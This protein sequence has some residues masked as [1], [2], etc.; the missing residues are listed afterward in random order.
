MQQ[1]DYLFKAAL[2]ILLPL[3]PAIAI[4]KAFPEAK[5]DGEGLFA[6]I[7]WK[8]GGAFGGYVLVSFILLFAMQSFREAQSEVWTVTGKLVAGK[9]IS[10]N[11]LKVT[12]QPNDF[13]VS[14]DGVFDIKLVGQR[15]GDRMRFPKL[16][17]DMSTECLAVKTVAV[18]GDAQTFDVLKSDDNKGLRIK[19][20]KDA[21]EIVVQTPIELHRLQHAC[22]V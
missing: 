4:F 14:E 13:N 12:T 19:I 9:P 18:D 20:D 6:G 22:P 3:V 16:V 5:A 17:F 2:V 10:R 21:K 15:K 8:L 7:K 11:V 1:Y